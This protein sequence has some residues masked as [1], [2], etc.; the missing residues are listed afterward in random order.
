LFW[1]KATR[2]LDNYSENTDKF[3]ASQEAVEKF[4]NEYYQ[5]GDSV[6]A[7]CFIT[8]HLYEV[9]ELYTL[10][11]QYSE[12]QYTDWYILDEEYQ[13]EDEYPADVI[14]QYE[15]VNPTDSGFI[16]IYRKQQ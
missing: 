4:L 9:D 14:E 6:S 15:C 5:E 3:K 1:S 8:P 7:Q 13:G 11:A 16:R 10:P 12:R 2:Y